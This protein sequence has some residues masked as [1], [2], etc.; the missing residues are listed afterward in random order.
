MPHASLQH[1]AH[2]PWPLPSRP[3]VLR[4]TWRDLLFLHWPVDPAVLRPLI[5]PALTLDEFSGSAW[6]A[7]TP[8]WISGAGFRRWG[9][10][11]L[12]A[13]FEELNVRTY[14]THDG[15]PG[16]WFFSLDAASRLA[17][18]GARRLY[19]LPYVHAQMDHRQENGTIA[20]RSARSDGTSFQASYGPSGPVTLSRPGSPEHWL[21]ERYCLYARG[22]SGELYRAEIHH[23][24][25]PL[26][27]AVA[28]IQRNDMLSVH[29][30]PVAGPPVYRHFSATLSVIV[31]PLE[32]LRKT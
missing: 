1:L 2:R 28:T 31:W 25:W 9:Q 8:F 26:Q 19:R 29:G 22:S 24:P 14:V 12:A 20:Y 32:P 17:V 18:W 10:V 16:V 27:P 11:P 23:E 4:Q 15:R 30:I 5:P 7:V 6:V 3:W 21:T 13:R